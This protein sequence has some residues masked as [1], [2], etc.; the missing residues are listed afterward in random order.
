MSS[1]IGLLRLVISSFNSRYALELLADA[2]LELSIGEEL[3][4][5]VRTQIASPISKRRRPRIP[6]L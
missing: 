4:P 6:N 3:I 5:V 2:E 1:L